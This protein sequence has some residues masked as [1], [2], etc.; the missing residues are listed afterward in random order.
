MKKRNLKIIILTVL[1]VLIGAIYS[2]GIWPRA[3]YNT[4]IGANSYEN[5]GKLTSDIVLTQMF[6]C[7]DKGLCGFSIKL[8]KLDNQ[9]IG[10]YSWSIQEAETGKEIG[11]GKINE[12]STENSEFVSSS[13]QKRGNVRVEF[14]VQADSA[15]KKYVLI[16][17]GK[18]VQDNET[19]AV[20]V[21]EKGKND[22]TL[23]LNG[24]KLE[25]ASV[26]KLQ[27]KRFNV[28]TFIVFL[29]IILYLAVFVKFMYKLFK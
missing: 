25:R 14:P 13:A 21:T 2:Y 24:T 20:Y 18:K 23:E 15:G 28:E 5:T 11:K 29:V 3:I 19:M 26:I 4:D 1:M 22:S 7:T 27:Y 9:Q 8:T 10:T 12:A 6:T 17:Q 16:I